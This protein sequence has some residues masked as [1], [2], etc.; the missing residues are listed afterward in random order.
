MHQMQPF[1][2]HHLLKILNE[3]GSSTLPLDA[4]MA[5]YFRAHKSLGS[6]DRKWISET[7]Y[8]IIRL[9]G[10]LDAYISKPA[11]W[12]KRFE[13]YLDGQFPSRDQL[14]KHVS[15]SF[16]KFLYDHLSDAICNALNEPAP[17][18]V[19]ANAL[20]ITREE[21]MERWPEY[22]ITKTEHSPVGITFLKKINFFVTPEFKQ[23]LFEVQDEGSQLVAF[24]VKAQPGDHVL[25]FCAGSGGKTL[26]IA[27]MMQGKGQLYLHDIR[28][29]AL[30]EA[31]RRLNRA[32]VQN[33]QIIPPDRLASLKGKMDWVLV[34]APC[35]GTGTLRRNPDMKWKL[36]PE[37]IE[38]LVDKQQKIFDQALTC[39]KP[40]GSIVYATCSI[41][42]CENEE[43]ITKF[44]K[45]TSLKAGPSFKS[46]PESGKMDGFF[47]QTMVYSGA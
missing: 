34:D 29:H 6:K 27:P 47:A 20:K 21:L 18:T 36:T 35:S 14:P 10:L 39:L 33:A 24:M 5:N 15:V 30:K 4:L 8:A 42:P 3:H 9:K 1:R 32:G 22:E 11:T 40:G 7:V 13:K 25:D 16:P 2:H 31:K 23:G 45:N 37:A 38:E 17:T 19:R 46:L 41:L 44:C 43:Q 12:E 28:L 26:A